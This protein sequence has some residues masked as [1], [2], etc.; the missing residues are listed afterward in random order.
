MRNLTFV[1]FLQSYL[2]D[3]SVSNSCSIRNL[4]KELDDNARILEPLI[5]FT[6]IT[7]TNEQQSKYKKTVVQNCLL[8]LSGFQDVENAL[9]NNL[10][11]EKY[12]KVYNSYLVKKNKQK[13]DDRIKT[14]FFEKIK[15]IQK[16]KNISNYNI[17]KNLHLNAGNINDYLRNKNVSKVSLN[18]ARKIFVYVNKL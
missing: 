17:Y 12:Q 14:M 10:L 13:R 6:K 5:L 4:I 8:E 3:L 11:P 18:T 2:V 1:G 15:I 9:E 16:E 7:T